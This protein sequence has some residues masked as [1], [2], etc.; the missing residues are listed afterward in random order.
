[1]DRVAPSLIAECDPQVSWRGDAIDTAGRQG[2]MVSLGLTTEGGVGAGLNKRQAGTVAAQA[3]RNDGCF[4]RGRIA[5]KPHR[6]PKV[7]LGAKSNCVPVRLPARAAVIHAR[8]QQANH[9]G[10]LA[11]WQV[12]ECLEM[13][14]GVALANHAA[15]AVRVFGVAPAR[16]LAPVERRLSMTFNSHQRRRCDGRNYSGSPQHPN[17][18]ALPQHSP[19]P[20]GA[21]NPGVCHV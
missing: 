13:R 7:I 2:N 20:P 3:F 10:R 9:C 11:I 15:I 17:L 16:N 21:G 8:A 12:R 1:M 5:A 14:L 18:H 19:A 6:C 4:A